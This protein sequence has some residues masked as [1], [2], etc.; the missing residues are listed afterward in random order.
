MM[1]APS[2]GVCCEACLKAKAEMLGSS[3]H[4]PAWLLCIILTEPAA[5]WWALAWLP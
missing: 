1:V 5:A 2:S 3:N 4:H